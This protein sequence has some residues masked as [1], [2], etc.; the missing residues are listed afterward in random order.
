VDDI[1]V[2]HEL[3]GVADLLE[4]GTDLSLRK[5]PFFLE[6]G[7]DISSAARLQN[8]IKEFLITKKAVKLNYVRVVKKT[9]NLDFP[10]QLI[11]IPCLSLENPFRN[12]F[13]G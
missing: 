1:I 12:L 2:M 13:Q 7:V 10:K 9:L 5:T 4:H 8:Q 6:I 11:D 3:D